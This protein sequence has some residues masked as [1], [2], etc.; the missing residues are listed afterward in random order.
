MVIYKE[1]FGGP[2]HHMFGWLRVVAMEVPLQLSEKIRSGEG[3]EGAEIH[4]YLPS[5]ETIPTHNPSTE[6]Q[7]LQEQ[8]LAKICCTYPNEL[9]IPTV[10]CTGFRCL[11]PGTHRALEGREKIPTWGSPHGITLLTGHTGLA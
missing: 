6:F 2:I 11:M 5:K 4:S 7:N 8:P 9:R 1:G 10:P 3:R